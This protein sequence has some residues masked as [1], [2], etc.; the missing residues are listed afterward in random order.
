M[1]DSYRIAFLV[2]LLKKPKSGILTSCN[3]LAYLSPAAAKFITAGSNF[4]RLSR[5][6]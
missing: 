1:V 4:I 5:G 2:Q 6:N 3:S